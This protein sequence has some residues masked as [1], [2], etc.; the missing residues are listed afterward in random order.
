MIDQPIF[1]SMTSVLQLARKFPCAPH[2]YGT[3]PPYPVVPG[4]SKC[5]FPSK[6]QAPEYRGA[7]ARDL[8]QIRMRDIPQI[9]DYHQTR[10]WYY[11]FS[12]MN[13]QTRTQR[14]SRWWTHASDD[15]CIKSERLRC[16]SVDNHCIEIPFK[17]ASGTVDDL[18]F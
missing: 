5:Y 9:T 10:F 11:I 13:P 1:D 4:S 16:V 8:Q 7:R 18:T 12:L 15:G 3:Y 6:K 17:E 14:A 2:G